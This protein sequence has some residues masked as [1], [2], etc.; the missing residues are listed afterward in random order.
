MKTDHLY[1]LAIDIRSH[2]ARGEEGVGHCDGA[3]FRKVHVRLG[4]VEFSTDYLPDAEETQ[5]LLHRLSPVPSE[6]NLTF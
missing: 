3:R 5:C 6:E 1:S 4:Y 2:G